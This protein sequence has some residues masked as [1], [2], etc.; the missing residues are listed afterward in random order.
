MSKPYKVV[1]SLNSL[2]ATSDLSDGLTCKVTADGQSSTSPVPFQEVFCFDLSDK[3]RKIGVSFLK[4]NKEIARGDLDVPSDI[5]KNVEIETTEVIKTS[6]TVNGKTGKELTAKFNLT[7]IN[8]DAFKGGNNKKT[9]TTPKK[10]TVTVTSSSKKLTDRSN[11]S[12]ISSRIDNGRGSKSPSRKQA[13]KEKISAN[14]LDGYL[15]RIVDKHFED[16]KNRVGKDLSETSDCLYLNKFNQ[17]ANSQLV[18]SGAISPSKRTYT[19]SVVHE[20]ELDHTASPERLKE[21]FRSSSRSKSPSRLGNNPD[22]TSIL[23]D[24]ETRRYVNEYKNQLEYLR[25]IVYALDSKL[26][27]TETC[28]R[29]VLNLREDNDRANNAR[30]ELRKTLLET[31]KD[32]K[33]ETDKFNQLVIDLENQN[34][35]ILRD[36]KTSNNRVDD[37]QTKLHG[38]EVRNGQLE[39]EN[40]ELRTKLKAGD[41]YKSQLQRITNEYANAEKRHADSMIQLSQRIEDLDGSLSKISADRN[42]LREENSRLQNANS[43][44]KVQLTQEKTNNGHLKDDLEGLN[45]KLKLTQGSIEVLKAVQDQRDQ[46]FKEAAKMKQ[47]NDQLVAQIENMERELVQKFKEGEIDER[48]NRDDLLKATRKI[49]DLEATIND[50]RAGSAKTRKDN[51]ELRN[52]IITLEQLLCVKEDVY[53]QLEAAQARLEARQNDVDKMR[54]TSEANIKVTEGLNDKILE[55]EKLVIYLKNAVTDKEDVT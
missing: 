33:D 10:S 28:K 6:T 26:Q 34:K 27:D 25:N 21:K 52:H 43:E 47:T 36:L 19:K 7:F 37:L 8:S 55:L 44:L 11:I 1:V 39:A 30:E 49:V 20:T 13:S 40:A 17:L 51:I 2:E 23:M 46:V 45:N 5:S 41:A 32:L 4:E 31:T 48:N 54:A 50:L 22:M 14:D 12:N 3:T 16:A 38:Q 42:K 9:S 35:D 15:N 18:N 24:T 29:E 53:S